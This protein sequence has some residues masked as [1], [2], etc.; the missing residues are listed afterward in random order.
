MKF[1][2]PGVAIIHFIFVAMAQ[3]PPAHGAGSVQQERAG[4]MAYDQRDIPDS[5]DDLDFTGTY[6]D[7]V[8]MTKAYL[9]NVHCRGIVREQVDQLVCQLRCTKSES[10]HSIKCLQTTNRPVLIQDGCWE[11]CV[12][13][14]RVNTPPG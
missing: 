3:V 13:G 8:I 11:L 9:E 5:T 14:V 10:N 1:K 4:N 12:V 2:A 7:E 6:L